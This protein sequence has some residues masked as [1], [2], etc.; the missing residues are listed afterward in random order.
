MFP[1]LASLFYRRRFTIL[2]IPPRPPINT[3]TENSSLLSRC[4]HIKH[5]RR[6]QEPPTLSFEWELTCEW[7]IR[8]A[9]EITPKILFF[10]VVVCAKQGHLKRKQMRRGQTCIFSWRGNISCCRFLN[11]GAKFLHLLFSHHEYRPQSCESWWS[12]S[13]RHI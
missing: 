3:T 7:S 2:R 4:P 11:Y 1:N 12:I 10:K 9:S 5:L 13:W 6:M 8:S